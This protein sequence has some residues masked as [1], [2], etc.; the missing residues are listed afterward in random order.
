MFLITVTYNCYTFNISSVTFGTDE[1]VFVKYWE[2]ATQDTNS[3]E[4]N[5]K[6]SFSKANFKR[7]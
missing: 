5:F 3:R 1:R 4:L 7:F 6:L 2:R